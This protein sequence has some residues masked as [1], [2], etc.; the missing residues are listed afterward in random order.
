M[1]NLFPAAPSS[2]AVESAFPFA[3]PEYASAILNGLRASSPAVAPFAVS[4]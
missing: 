4:E 2:V 3:L 1:L